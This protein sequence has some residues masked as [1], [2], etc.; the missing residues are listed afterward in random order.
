MKTRTAKIFCSKAEA[1]QLGDTVEV[2]E[3]YP[4]FVLARAQQQVLAEVARRF[5]VEDITSQFVI[6][7]GG[8]SIDTEKARVDESGKVRAHPAYK[9]VAKLVRGKHHYLVQFNGP[10]KKSW[11]AALRKL[12]AEPRVPFDNFV[13]VVRCTSA[14]LARVAKAPYVRW[15]GHLSHRDRIDVES[16]Q[17]ALPRTKRLPAA[18]RVEFFGPDDLR[19]GKRSLTGAG[20]KVLASHESAAVATVEVDGDAAVASRKLAKLSSIHGVRSVRRYSFKRTSNDVATTLMSTAKMSAAPLDLS[21][22]GEVIAVCDTGLDTGVLASL[23]PDFANRVV[24]IKSYPITED[25]TPYIRNPNGDDGGADLDS[26]HGTHVAGSVLGSGA[27]SAKLESRIRGLAYRARLVFQAVEQEVRWRDPQD[28]LEYGRYILAG[29]PEDLTPLFKYAYD[30]G[31]RIHSNSWGGGEPGEYDAQCTQLDQFVWKH[32]DFCVL[33]AAGNDGT[34]QDGDGLINRMSVTAPGTAKN[35]ITVGA[36]ESLRREFNA[37]RYGGW[38]PDDYPVAPYKNA[39]MANGRAQV[40]PFSSRGP[41][42]DGRT[43]PDVIAPGTYIL[44]TRSRVLSSVQ[45]GWAPFAP[46]SHY[47]YMGGTSM[48]T[49]LTAGAVACVRQFL[50]QWVGFESPSAALLKAALV[51]AAT[52]LPTPGPGGVAD[53]DQGYGLVNVDAIVAA[54]VH[55]H[56]DDVG[57]ETGEVDEFE[58]QVKSATQPLR[59]AMAYSDYPGPNLVNNLNLVLIAPSGRMHTVGGASQ[60]ALQLDNTNNVEVIRV[61]RPQK[62][63]WRLRVIGS[64]VAHGP[65]RYAFTLSGKVV[66]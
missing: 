1:E 21:G 42:Q 12:G 57:L 36:S 9:G 8:R 51:G 29:I 47:F 35:C 17:R 33:V 63:S 26:G 58:F 32:Q 28:L 25:L 52:P 41:T 22:Q 55:F 46:N 3:A 50:R 66:F 4:G 27:A 49:P 14:M 23:H 10:I 65:Q 60:G 31:A 16:T 5:P 62:G 64:N 11:L 24:A 20:V 34:D 40:V 37:E 56:D 54:D 38:W 43:K 7:V 13:Y 61:A 48:A 44:S 30:H 53:N 15:V 59:V 19:K 18:Y 6:R 45:H 2:L 39:P